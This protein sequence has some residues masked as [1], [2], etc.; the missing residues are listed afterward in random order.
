MISIRG[1]VKDNI[2]LVLSVFEPILVKL[3]RIIPDLD[4]REDCKQE[5]RL[6]I[7]R[8]FKVEDRVFTEAYVTQRLKWD[9]IN[10]LNRDS[11]YNFSKNSLFVDDLF[12]FTHASL[13]LENDSLQNMLF[14]EKKEALTSII[15]RCKNKMTKR[16]YEALMLYLSCEKNRVIKQFYGLENKNLTRYYI[17]LANAVDILRKEIMDEH[18]G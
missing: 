15:D 7:W 9:T 4:S 18:T 13:V 10:F 1:E 3:V 12:D 8:L 11:I 17:N 6:I 5:L 16:E 2:E 14:T